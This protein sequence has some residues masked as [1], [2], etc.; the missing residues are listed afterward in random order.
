MEL[1][2]G[3]GA[4][5]MAPHIALSEAGTQYKLHTVTLDGSQ[6]KSPY[7]DINPK[8]SVPALKTDNGEILT[9]AALILQYIGDQVPAKNLIPK[10]GTMERYRAQEM[11]NYIATE[12]H[13]GIGAFF[14]YSRLPNEQTKKDMRE[15]SMTKLNWHFGIM[16]KTLGKNQ[17]VLGSQFTVADGY[18]FTVLNW[19]KPMGIDLTPYKNIMGFMERMT[20]RPS[21]QAAMKE[22]GIIQ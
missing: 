10:A 19:C 4:C 1:Y 5:S 15:A 9:E 20:T 6:K 2:Y 3:K 16:D 17:F 8:G 14:G 12:F 11:L 7:V 18:L 13:K 21:V 22:E